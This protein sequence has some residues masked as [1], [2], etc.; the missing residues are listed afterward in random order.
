MKKI[1]KQRHF[2]DLGEIRALFRGE[3]W[4]KRQYLRPLSGVLP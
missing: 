2:L 4:A 3:K 1:K